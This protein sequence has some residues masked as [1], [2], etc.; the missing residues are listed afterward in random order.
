VLR[1]SAIELM[2]SGIG[3]IPLERMIAVTGELLQAAVPV[4]LRIA[5]DPVPLSRIEQ[6]WTRAAGSSRIVVTM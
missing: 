3:S 6:S 1:A 5:V 2:G 4:G